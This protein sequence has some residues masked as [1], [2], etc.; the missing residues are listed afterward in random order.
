MNSIIL[1]ITFLLDDSF[2]IIPNSLSVNTE[3]GENK[4]DYSSEDSKRPPVPVK[5]IDTQLLLENHKNSKND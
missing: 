1:L 2:V 5:R 3:E 4:R